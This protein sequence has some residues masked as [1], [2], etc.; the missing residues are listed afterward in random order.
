MSF[1][2]SCLRGIYMGMRKKILFGFV[3][4]AIMLFLAGAWSIY[5]LRSV[6]SSVQSLL[7]DNYR[8]INAAN[9][10]MEALER[11]DSAILLLL[12]GHWEQGRK[13]IESGDRSFQEAFHIAENNITIP[14]EKTYIAEI[15]QAYGDY[16]ELWIRPI[17]GTSREKNLDWY[18]QE[19]HESFLN[20]KLTVNR[21]RA[22]NAQV[23]Y[24]T[25]SQVKEKAHRA[26]IPGVVAILAALIFT[27]IFNYFVN[28][29]MVSPIIK[30][31][32]SVQD[33][34]KTNKPFKLQVET[35]D[36]LQHLAR[37][38]DNLIAQTCKPP[39]S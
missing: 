26:V 18:F 22:L 36:E 32:K 9:S 2:Y 31:T 28:H 8:S 34:L 11:E 17:V 29:Y 33:F 20:V 14:E 23:M 12:S 24:E 38:I 4:L 6:G 13:I 30:M 15:Q 19:A 7:D 21:L 10:M 39:A 5:E 3:I 35:Q 37:A 25:A 1:G 16:K 27:L